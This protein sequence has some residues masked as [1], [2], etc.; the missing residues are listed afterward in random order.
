MIP[1]LVERSQERNS[2]ERTQR[3]EE[4]ERRQRIV[5]W[6]YVVQ[7]LKEW[8]ARKWSGRWR[9]S[10]WPGCWSQVPCVCT[11][12]VVKWAADVMLHMDLSAEVELGPDQPRIAGG[13]LSQVRLVCLVRPDAS[14]SFHTLVL[15][16][17]P[18]LLLYSY[19]VE[20]SVTH[21]PAQGSVSRDRINTNCRPGG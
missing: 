8:V 1:T 15:I 2:T 7:A 13:V 5:I 20:G 3:E 16:H 14:A 18:H 19:L 6:A 9:G 4:I 12:Y 10:R 21:N 11:K 17:A